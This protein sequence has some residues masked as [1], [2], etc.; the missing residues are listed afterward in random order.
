MKILGVAKRNPPGKQKT[1]R[2]KRLVTSVR[3]R[4]SSDSKRK[5]TRKMAKDF[6]CSKATIRNVL[7]KDLGLRPYRK[8][9]VPRLKKSHIDKR[10][11]C[12]NWIRKHIT[13][14]KTEKM[15]WT[16]KKIFTSDGM[17]NTKNYVI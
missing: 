16:D 4:L 15:I 17:L 12:C 9:P 6:N 11:A 3:N 5:S 2:T 8:I 13:R 10:K 7:H 1:V 14:D